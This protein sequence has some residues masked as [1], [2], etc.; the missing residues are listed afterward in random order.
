MGMLAGLAVAAILFLV[1]RL[2]ALQGERAAE[3]GGAAGFDPDDGIIAVPTLIW[4][5]LAEELLSV[6]AVGAPVFAVFFYW[7]LLHNRARTGAAS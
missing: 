7:K 6:A 2:E 3:L 5:N 4:F 1:L